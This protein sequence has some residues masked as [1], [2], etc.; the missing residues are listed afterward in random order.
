M[1]YRL[2]NN[3]YSQILLGIIFGILLGHFNAE[4]AVKFKPLADAFLALIKML[5]SPIVFLVVVSSLISLKEFSKVGKVAGYAMLY[6]MVMTAFA[7]LIGAGVAY[8]FQPGSVITVDLSTID[9]NALTPYLNPHA[10]KGTFVSTLIPRTFTSAFVEG[11]IIQILIIAIL[12]GMALSRLGIDKQILHDPIQ[13]LSNTFFKIM[14]FILKFAPMSAFAAMAFSVGFFGLSILW[15][16]FFLVA[17]FYIT[18]FIF[19][20]GI[21]GSLLKFS[22]GISMWRFLW[23][24][25]EELLIVIGTVSSESV[26]PRLMKKLE[27][28]GVSPDVVRLVLPMGYSSNLDGSLIYLTLASLFIA[29]ATHVDLTLPQFF[30][31]IALMYGTSKGSAPIAGGAMVVLAS[32]LTA[33]E[34]IPVEGILLIL[35]VDRFLAEIRALTNV[36]GNAAATVFIA[37]RM[38]S[39]DLNP[40]CLQ[41]TW[42]E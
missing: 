38:N 22:S 24:L 20:F 4:L 36:I 8:L 21:L 42:N 28:L 3:I 35:G 1:I 29:Q 30:W 23:Y 40:E 39:L 27:R 16:L 5:I 31:L 11:N 19:I 14:E 17:C 10:D 2:L 32:V 25:R 18:C 34:I 15:K 37:A 41:I 12:F 9:P 13:S 7:L 26:L 6:F 33:F